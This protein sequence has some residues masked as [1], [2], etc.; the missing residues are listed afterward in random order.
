MAK[1]NITVTQA[2]RNFA[3]VVNR[4]HYQKLSFVLLKN[5]KPVARIVP[6][7]V[8]NPLRRI[9]PDTERIC[10]GRQLA[11]ALAQVRLP[12]EEAKAWS[13]DLRNARKKLKVPADKWR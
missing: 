5:G 1:P 2:S 4:V 11:E 3:D 12:K 7:G 6:G 9:V 13:R 10:T 8:I